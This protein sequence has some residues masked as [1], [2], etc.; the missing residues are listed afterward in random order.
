[1]LGKGTQGTED[2]IAALRGLTTGDSTIDSTIQ[3]VLGVLTTE[4]AGTPI[5]NV[6]RTGVITPSSLVLTDL[7]ALEVDSGV[8]SGGTQ[9]TV[10]PSEEAGIILSRGAASSVAA[11]NSFTLSSLLNTKISTS[12]A[13]RFVDRLFTDMDDLE[14]IANG[15]FVDSDGDIGTDDGPVASLVAN[16]SLS[17]MGLGLQR[18]STVAGGV[19]QESST[20]EGDLL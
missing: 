17:F 15:T 2:A 4:I 9:F 20:E 16:L 10:T 11:L 13:T 8:I 14:T 7:E 12:A 18:Q 5:W 1:M 3:C 19:D 6:T